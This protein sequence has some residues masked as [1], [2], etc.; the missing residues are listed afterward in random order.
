MFKDDIDRLRAMGLE[1]TLTARTS[2][3][4]PRIVMEG[5]EY[6]NF[7]SNDYLSLA[8]DPRLLSAAGEAVMRYGAGGGASRLLGGGCEAHA[9]LERK[10]ADFKRAEAALFFASGYAANTGAI[11]ALAGRGDAIFSDELNHASIIDG[12]RLSR[13]VTHIY[14]HRDLDHLGRLLAASGAARRL[15]V[16]DT[17]F[18]MTGELAPVDRIYKCCEAHGAML[19]LDDAHGTGVLGAG[20]GALEHFGLSVQPWLIQMGTCSKALGTQGAFIA[21]SADV[22]RWL[23]NKAR[24]FIYSTAPSPAIVAAAAA[25]IDAVTPELVARLWANQALATEALGTPSDTPIIALGTASCTLEVAAAL[26]ARGIYAPAIRPPT[27]PEALIRITVTAG[28]A[29]EDIAELGRA[30]RE[31]LK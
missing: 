10:L 3:Q 13:A 30:V 16:T 21:A 25:A 15:V 26:L 28:H 14:R 22:V 24:S 11:A 20:H 31:A 29:P 1:R 7:A 17:V 27:V 23:I 6:I 19:Y 12:C 5:R 2:K 9:C 4:G 8:S 18:S